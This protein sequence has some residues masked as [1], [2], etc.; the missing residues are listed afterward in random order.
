M[1]VPA[2]LRTVLVRAASIAGAV[3]RVV[4]L[5]LAGLLLV[6][7]AMLGVMF[8]EDLALW[9]NGGFLVK[10]IL[11]SGGEKTRF[12][13]IGPEVPWDEVCVIGPGDSEGY[14]P[15]PL[16]SL[17]WEAGKVLPGYTVEPSSP[18]LGESDHGLVF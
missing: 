17:V 6:P 9:P 11:A 13:S 16:D 1:S 15:T 14:K 18:L 4:A 12:S 3:L 7:G 5:C 10:R 8:Y 2:V